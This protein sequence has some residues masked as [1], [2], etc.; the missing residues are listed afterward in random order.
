MLSI[1]P[2]SGFKSFNPLKA[3]I[4]L[5][6]AGAPVSTPEPEKATSG[7]PGGP[8]TS[9]ARA[10]LVLIP[11]TATAKT[12]AASKRILRI[13]RIPYLPFRSGRN[14]VPG[15]TNTATIG[16]STRQEVPATVLEGRQVGTR[17]LHSWR[18]GVVSVWSRAPEAAL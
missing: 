3:Q 7:V 9:P 10:A 8:V 14:F 17:L 16:P 1:G 11:V 2:C 4:E 18:C 13:F 12:V 6:C 5:A 15:E